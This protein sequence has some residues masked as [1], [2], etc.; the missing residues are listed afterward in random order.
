MTLLNQAPKFHHPGHRSVWETVTSAL[1]RK[2]G[3]WPAWSVTIL[4]ALLILGG[5]L[6]V[7]AAVRWWRRSQ[8]RRQPGLTYEIV[9][10]DGSQWEP[11]AWITFYRALYGMSSPWWTR[12]A[13]GQ[14]WVALEFIAAGG[15]VAAR[16]WF[17][18]RLEAMLRAQLMTA[19]S[20]HSPSPQPDPG[21][22]CGER[23]S[24]HSGN[25]RP[26]PCGASSGLFP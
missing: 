12:V 7:L 9:P 24:I 5:A 19:L 1:S 13:F 17:R 2:A 11:A 16:C 21:F 3:H 4:R 18:P 8:T 6:L 22:T 25:Q 23:S 14:P 15:R 26:M 10:R 20:L